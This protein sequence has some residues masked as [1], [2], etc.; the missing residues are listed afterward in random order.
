M[1][2]TS[3]D[4]PRFSPDPNS[5]SVCVSNFGNGNNNIVANYAAAATTT[6]VVTT[7][8]GGSSHEGETKAFGLG[9]FTDAGAGDGPWAVD[10]D[11]GDASAHAEFDVTSVGSLG[12]KDHAYADNGSIHGHREGHR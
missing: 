1:N 10:V 12:S 5:L 4:G 11:W 6:P 8:V 3:E 2:W 9:S 7:P